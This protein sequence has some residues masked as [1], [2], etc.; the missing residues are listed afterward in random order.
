MRFVREGSRGSG[1]VISS[2]L[3]AALF[4][5]MCSV[6]DL[7]YGKPYD[8]NETNWELFGTMS[9]GWDV[10]KRS[11]FEDFFGFVEVQVR[12]INLELTPLHACKKNQQWETDWILT[13]A[14]I[15]EGTALGRIRKRL[16]KS[17]NIIHYGFLGS[18]MS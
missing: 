6:H 3:H 4:P 11:L 12:T 1:C 17:T 5:A 9:S 10:H 7:P 15:Q 2:V 8:Y 16:R 14:Q 13:L 18:N